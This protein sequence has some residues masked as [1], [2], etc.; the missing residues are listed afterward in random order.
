ME[1]KR[2]SSF[3]LWET[4][5]KVLLV[6]KLKL[7]L[8]LIACCQVSA[9][10]HSQ[11]QALNVCLKD[12]SLEQVI[13]ELEEKTDFTFM[14]WIADIKDVKVSVDMKQK[15]IHDILTYCL[16][17]TD[18]VYEINGDAVVIHRV[19]EVQTKE[20]LNIIKGLVTDENGTPLPGV[21]VIEKG[22]KSGVATNVKG[23]FTY[24]SFKD[25]VTFVF[26][27]IGMK[28]KTATWTGQKMFAIVLEDDVQM[29]DEVVVTGYQT[30]KKR[31]MAGSSSHVKAE[32]LVMTGTQ[33]LEQALQGKI[34]GMTVTNQSGL[35]GSRQRVR[36]RGTSTL[37]GSAEP[38]WVVDGI[39][40]EDPL[41]FETNELTNLNPDNMDMIKDFVGGAISWLNPNDIE[42]ITV[43]KDAASTAIY[44]VKAA[45][46]VI[47]INT[48][49]GKEGRMALNYNSSVTFTPRL[50]Y[51]RMELMNSQERVAVSREAYESG[52]LLGSQQEMGYLGLALAF[53]RKEISLD[54]FSRG[55]KKLETNNTDWFDFLFRNAVSH[56]HNLSVSGGSDKATYRASFGYND[57]R[58]TAIGNNQKQY[59][60]NLSM[61]ANLWGCVSL[62]FGLSGSTS[63]TSSF[64]GKD[65]FAYASTTNRAL[66]AYDAQGKLSFYRLANGY[67]FNVLNELQ[68][69]GNMNT[70]SNLNANMNARWN[71]GKGLYYNTTFSYNYSSV[72]GET[73]YSE[74][75]NYIA[76]IRGYDFEA[77]AE[78]T[79][80]YNESPLP[81]GGERSELRNSSQGW[82]WRNQLEYMKLFNE[83]HSFSAMIGQEMRSSSSS[84][85]NMTSYGYL[86]DKGKIFVDIPETTIIGGLEWVNPYLKRV[87]KI[88][89]TK[90][91]NL[92]F[93][94]A[95]SYMYDNRY[96]VNLS[97]RSDA[98]NQFGQDK[99]TRF[100]PVW[101]TGFRWN[102]GSEHWLEGQD[103]LSDM[104]IRFTYGFQGNVASG[105]SPDL[106][107]TITKKTAAN[108]GGY[109]LSVDKLP[110]PK[111]KWEKV[112]SINV[113][114]D[115]ALFK[116][117]IL[118][119]FE[120]YSKRTSDMVVNK[121]V[122][123]ENGVLSRPIN[124]GKMKNSGWDA[125]VSFT[126]LR[127]KDMM[128]SL[129]FN[130]GMV[131]NEINSTLEPQGN[132]REA[133]SGN[134]N[135]EGY[136]VSSFW[137]YRFKGLNPEHGGPEFDLNGIERQGAEAD[138]TMYMEYAGK[139][140]P[141]FTAGVS[142]T[143]RYKTLSLTSGLYFSMGNQQFLAP[144]GSVYQSI[145]GEEYNM[146]TEWLNRWRKPGD[147]KT[148]HVPSLPNLANSAEEIPVSLG[149]TRK[150]QPYELYAFST[151]RVVDAWYLRC[152]NIQLSYTVP[153]EK[154]PKFLQNFSCSFSLSN[155]FQIRSKDFLG[156]DPEVALG[157]QP[158]SH[159][160]AFSL[161]VSF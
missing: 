102:V 53:E 51:N 117:H 63:E 149:N 3:P 40:Q 36:V 154:L 10:V 141:D 15:S 30:V 20:Q 33:T 90:T 8:V 144:M 38:V 14:Y 85:Y 67:E 104:N 78:G 6:M 47:V 2:D 118:G 132:W 96:S 31:S 45:N 13:W 107:A 27:F 68:N 100:L 135:K 82:G 52:A 41:P 158:M 103:I 91:N 62:T 126:P 66:E 116:N 108:G 22:T 124:G 46:G 101:A 76:A 143:F 4:W 156:R 37:L 48:K 113:G 23:E 157:N 125:T 151:A 98:S 97:V 106:I 161:S 122:P 70:Q 146:S 130:F 77:Y 35:T 60:G 94:T 92:S 75:T 5:R 69:S 39:I 112:Q 80:K 9:A 59:T 148:T 28:T 136:A 134:L 54:E 153:T 79:D 133:A 128:L 119:S 152:N 43:L 105:V 83:V 21:T 55:V 81:V 131:N 44:G 99:S 120:W 95:L 140:D 57:T 24:S 65:P 115:F 16:R 64:I 56:N 12:V 147:E 110:A 74:Q 42:D 72:H 123:M 19:K 11:N 88:T 138:A 71:I 111:L 155:P 58:N 26:S 87:P 86:P 109:A 32:D 89:D 150:L 139:L 127:T 160:Y 129:G 25:T 159:D 84:G 50:N 1:K 49:K 29:V 17:N 114:T 73:Y 142:F 34:P 18:L 145:P 121:D 137:A 61:S 7:F 93:Y